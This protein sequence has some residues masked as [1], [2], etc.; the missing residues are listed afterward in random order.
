M[1]E[2]LKQMMLLTAQQRDAVR[3]YDS[4]KKMSKEDMAYILEIARLSPSSV[5]LEGWRFVVLENES[6]KEKIKAVSWGGK[7]QIETASY[8][9][10]ALSAR[11]ARYDSAIMRKS[12]VRRGF[13]DEDTLLRINE[14]YRAFQK[15]DMRLL[16]SDRALNDWTAKQT[17]IALGNMMIAAAFIGID[18]CAIEGFNYEKVN[19]ILAEHHV[20]N[21]ETEGIAY[22]VSFGYR[23]KPRKRDK[24]RR[25]QEEVINWVE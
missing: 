12:L 16:E 13:T 5:G 21:L 15:E 9:V 22:M 25:P 17:Y 11:N 10:L 18:S 7:P 24:V 1:K 14:T 4:N 2:L 23:L 19:T 6:I 8:I 3:V 20:L